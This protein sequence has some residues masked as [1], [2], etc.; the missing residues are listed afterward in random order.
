MKIPETTLIDERFIAHCSLLIAHCS[1]LH[2][3]ANEAQLADADHV[4][5]V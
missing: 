4:A 1:L 2:L 5:V 3:E